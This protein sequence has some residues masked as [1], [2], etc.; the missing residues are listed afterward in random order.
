[1]KMSPI[2]KCHQNQNVTKAEM[3]YK[4]KYQNNLSFNKT[5][6]SPKLKFH[7]LYLTKTFMSLQQ[8]SPLNCNIL[9]LNVTKT[10]PLKTNKLLN[11]KFLPKQ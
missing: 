11:Q 10:L 1:M 3:T 8:K 9:N 7:Q 6:M 2:L 4:L 5:E